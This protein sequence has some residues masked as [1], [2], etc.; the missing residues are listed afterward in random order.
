MFGRWLLVVEHRRCSRTIRKTRVRWLNARRKDAGFSCRRW[1][2]RFS[3]GFVPSYSHVVSSLVLFGEN[4]PHY[5]RRQEKRGGA[6]GA[7]V[8]DSGP[9]MMAPDVCRPVNFVVLGL[10][11]PF[12]L[13]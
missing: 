7:G 9:A 8:L 6:P 2:S 13:L 10:A 12:P 3:N 11:V 4:E 5:G 1:A